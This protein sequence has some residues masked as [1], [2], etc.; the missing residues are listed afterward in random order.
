MS[1]N[2][3]DDPQTNN[4][5]PKNKTG[6]RSYFSIHVFKKKKKTALFSTTHGI[7]DKQHDKNPYFF[8]NYISFL[9]QNVSDTSLRQ[10][11]N[12]AKFIYIFFYVNFLFFY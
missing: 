12:T 8:N 6:H 5:I 4:N 1:I 7:H 2:E 9:L 10:Q 3:Y 11:K